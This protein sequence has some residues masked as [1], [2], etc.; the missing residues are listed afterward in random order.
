MAQM[1]SRTPQFQGEK[2]KN[3]ECVNAEFTQ[4]GQ[5]QTELY[6]PLQPTK[7]KQQHCCLFQFDKSRDKDVG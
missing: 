1:A 7:P 2:K 5:T 3:W 6:N 4:T